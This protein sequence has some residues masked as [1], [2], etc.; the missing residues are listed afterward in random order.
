MCI[1]FGS[2]TSLKKNVK[3][4]GVV[5][6]RDGYTNKNADVSILI[7]EINKKLIK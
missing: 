1:N 7:P 6:K 2:T 3:V 5:G 4:I